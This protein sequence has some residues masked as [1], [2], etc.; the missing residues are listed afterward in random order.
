MSSARDAS[1][2][3][4]S[5]TPSCAC[6]TRAWRRPA[7]TTRRSSTEEQQ[8]LLSNTFICWQI[9]TTPTFRKDRSIA[10][11]AVGND[12]DG[13][14]LRPWLASVLQRAVPVRHD[15]DKQ[16]ARAPL[17]HHDNW[18]KLRLNT[19]FLGNPDWPEIRE[20]LRPGQHWVDQVFQQ[21]SL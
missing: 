5:S 16:H 18:F 1:G 11:Q 2:R 20:R 13:T 19:K 9:E 12:G 3:F 8:R 14:V 15:D 10:Q 21:E 6:T 17:L 4:S 7:N